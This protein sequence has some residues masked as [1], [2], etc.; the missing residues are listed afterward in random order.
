MTAFSEACK[1]PAF[2]NGTEG[3]AWMDKWCGYCKRD[4]E[5]HGDNPSGGCSII[6]SH[7]VDHDVWPEAWLPEPDDGEFYLPSRMVCLAFESCTESGCNGDP[8]ATD[9]L[10]R[11]A[12]VTAY[13]QGRTIDSKKGTISD[14]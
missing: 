14:S 2:S 4:H 5:M 7:M 9:R 13:W 1:G 12:E 11:L 3:S 10:E 8:G 6:L